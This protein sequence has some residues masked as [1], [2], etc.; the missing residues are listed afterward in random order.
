MK[1]ADN[2]NPGIVK[3]NETENLN[4][5]QKKNRIKTFGVFHRENQWK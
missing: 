3:H 1:R 4:F 5:F 2:E